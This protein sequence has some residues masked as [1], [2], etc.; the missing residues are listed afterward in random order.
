MREIVRNTVGDNTQFA[1]IDWGNSDLFNY[2]V[3]YFE[4]ADHD[5][6]PLPFHENVEWLYK[7][8]LTGEEVSF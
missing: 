6:D 1:A 7:K 2:P 3:F 4:S 5:A 8:W